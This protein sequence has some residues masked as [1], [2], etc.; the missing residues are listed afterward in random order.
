[1]ACY[2]PSESANVTQ[3]NVSVA[4][5]AGWPNITKLTGMATL[6]LGDGMLTLTFASGPVFTGPVTGTDV[7]LTY[8][9]DH[10]YNDGCTWRATETLTGSYDAT[11]CD[12]SL[13]YAY[14]EGPISGFN[15][16]S[17]CNNP[18]TTADLAITPTP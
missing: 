2:T 17:A 4:P 12:M 8:T 7:T 18:P 3:S 14:Q 13:A 15:C 11:T 5:C 9:Q 6:A 10:H 1:M 16:F